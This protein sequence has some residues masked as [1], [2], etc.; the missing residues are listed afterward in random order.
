MSPTKEERRSPLSVA[1]FDE[2]PERAFLIARTF[3]NEGCEPAFCRTLDETYALLADEAMDILFCSIEPSWDIK[4]LFAFIDSIKNARTAAKPDPPYAII[5]L[6][7]GMFPSEPELFDPIDEVLFGAVSAEILQLA[8]R[9]A[10]IACDRRQKSARDFRII[11]SALDANPQAIAAFDSSTGIR[12]FANVHYLAEPGAPATLSDV[13][14]QPIPGAVSNVRIAGYQGELAL[15]IPPKARASD[16]DGASPVAWKAMADCAGVPM[17]LADAR[18]RVAAFN[19]IAPRIFLPDSLKINSELALKFDRDP[20]EGFSSGHSTIAKSQATLLNGRTIDVTIVAV[21]SLVGFQAYSLS[22]GERDESLLGS[23]PKT[24]R[25]AK[26]D[27]GLLRS[28]SRFPERFVKSMRVQSSLIDTFF[29]TSKRATFLLDR[30]GIARRQS[31]YARSVFG[32]VEGKRGGLRKLIERDD[33]PRLEFALGAAFKA[34]SYCLPLTFIRESGDPEPMLLTVTALFDE[35]VPY[36]FFVECDPVEGGEPARATGM[37]AFLDSSGKPLFVIGYNHQ[38]ILECNSS[39]CAIS[40]YAKQELV[41]L[42]F[43]S[44]T[45]REDV[46][47]VV[48]AYSGSDFC[49]VASRFRRKDGSTFHARLSSTPFFSSYLGGPLSIIAVTDL[50]F[51]RRRDTALDDLLRKLDGIADHIHAIRAPSLE[52]DGRE[53]LPLSS[54]GLTKRQLEVARCVVNGMSNKQIAHALGSSEASVKVHVFNIYRKLGVRNRVELL[55]FVQDK[56]TDF[57]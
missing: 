31:S 55:T 52:R 8:A 44:L 20:F 38:T 10:A 18:L 53:A 50:T 34:G 15:H 29:A 23:S 17:I 21:S 48:S 3:R 5:T 13:Q 39:A 54:F 6:P 30:S 49:D 25:S 36:G 26:E 47:R 22:L 32:I 35:K 40:G 28:M 46:D 1:I 16:T 37:N 14:A 57:R 9:K 33:V 24:G 12:L 41:G 2:T 51:E 19:D 7:E 4:G 42:T 56:A 27:E 45:P 43:S 11:K